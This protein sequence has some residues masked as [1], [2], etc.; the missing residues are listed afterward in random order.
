VN[1]CPNPLP[2]IYDFYGFPE[3]YYKAK[4]PYRASDGVSQRVIDV[5][6]E[7]GVEAVGMERGLDH[8][9]WVPF[10]VVFEGHEEQMP[11]IVQVSLFDSEDAE[12]HLQLGRAVAKLRQENILIVVSGMAVHNLRDMRLTMADSKPLN[13]T[14]SFDEALKE[15]V[16]SEPGSQRDGKM[17]QLVERSDA[18]KAHPTFEH[19]LPI[20]IGVGAAGSDKGNRLWTMGQGSMSWA[21]FRF[22]EV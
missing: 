1:T 9:V 19:L 15:A 10:K 12:Q 5:L 20:H 11:P 6:R 14:V 7:A 22:G 17:K 2:L 8:G 18:R 4:F 21:Q 13:Y 3:H 16:E